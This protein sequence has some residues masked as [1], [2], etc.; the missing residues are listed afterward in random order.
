VLRAEEA[1]VGQI[2][3]AVGQGVGFNGQM[4]IGRATR[5]RG[6]GEDFSGAQ[7]PTQEDLERGSPLGSRRPT[8]AGELGRQRSGQ[9]NRGGV[10]D[11]HGGE[12][13]EEPLGLS[14]RVVSGLQRVSE[15]LFEELPRRERETLVESL[16]RE[17]EFAS[18]PPRMWSWDCRS[19]RRREPERIVAR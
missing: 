15:E 19:T 1:Q 6:Q 13:I 18:Q 12:P 2:Q 3:T 14:A 17:I 16:G 5:V 10:F 4:A 11:D 9:S 7:I 8:T